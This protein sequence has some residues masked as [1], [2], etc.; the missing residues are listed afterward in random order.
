MALR[1]SIERYEAVVQSSNDAIITA[2]SRGIIVAW[3][4]C[5]AKIF[6]YE[7]SEIIGQ[8]LDSLMPL[9]FRTDHHAK[10]KRI[11]SGNEINILDRTVELKGLRKDGSEFDIDL[12]IA[13][14]EVADGIY[15]T[16]TVR[17]ITQRKTEQTLRILSEVVRQSPE[18]I[19]ITDTQACIEYVNEAFTVHRLPQGEEV[20]GKNP[21]ILQSGKLPENLRKD[22]DRWYKANHGV[23]NSTTDTR[24]AAYSRN[25]Q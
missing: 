18:S 20:I 12:S 3:N 10:M 16:S 23:A 11:L 7:E 9:R 1:A 14:W 17:D 21:N 13:R 15:F 24:M 4:P 6:G 22:V 2:D 8:P 19:V 5:A 25:L